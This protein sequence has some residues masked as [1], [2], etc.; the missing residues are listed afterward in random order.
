ML[1][2]QQE[3]DNRKIGKKFTKVILKRGS[4]SG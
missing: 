3:K 2:E 4:T 1:A